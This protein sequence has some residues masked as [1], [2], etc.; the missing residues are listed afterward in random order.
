MSL[1]GL[2]HPLVRRLM[3][4]HRDIAPAD[5]GLAGRLPS[6]VDLRGV[7]TFWR[8][9]IRGGKGQVQQR[10]ATIGLNAQGER[11]RPLEQLDDALLRLKPGGDPLLDSTRRTDLVRNV[12]P[13]MI[14]RDL[15]H[16]GVLPDGASFA[17]KLLAWVEIS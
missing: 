16:A 15:A 6:S 14:R 8:V 12:V 17:A 1:L 3:G 11:S 5:R 10:V 13:E 4:V 7:I 2:E 9:E